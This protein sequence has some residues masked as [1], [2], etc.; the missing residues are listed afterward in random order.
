MHRQADTAVCRATP[1][2]GLKMNTTTVINKPKEKLWLCVTERCRAQTAS[3]KI[4][5]FYKVKLVCASDLSTLLLDI[6][7]ASFVTSW[8]F[9]SFT[10]VSEIW[11]KCSICLLTCSF[12]QSVA[13]CVCTAVWCWTGITQLVFKAEQL[14]AVASKKQEYKKPQ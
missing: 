12:K 5:Q 2:T 14:S 10:L 1:L 7:Q 13:D 9:I 8:S 3:L 6:S 11:V 4:C